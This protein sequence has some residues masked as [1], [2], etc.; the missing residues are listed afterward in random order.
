[1]AIDWA[2]YMQLA[3]D[4]ALRGKAEGEFPFGCVVVDPQ[5]K[6]IGRRYD[7]AVRDGDRSAHCETM[8]VKELC[9]E[10]GPDLIDCTMVTTTESCPMC[11][12]TAWLARIGR[13]VY[14]STMAQ[15]AEK[16]GN[17]LREFKFPSSKLNGW[18]GEPV[19][20]IGG[21]LLE[22]CLAL[23]DDLTGIADPATGPMAD[24]PD[25]P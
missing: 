18:D 2:P 13:V 21:V 19:E 4:E 16:T 25:E 8:L 20:L 12:T 11:F 14:G 15:V 10:Y 24:T 9:A 22:P 5:G 17:A 6:V 7:T 1:M 23:F 3:I